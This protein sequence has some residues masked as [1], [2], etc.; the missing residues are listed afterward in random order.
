M[1]G[2]IVS[3]ANRIIAIQRCDA[4][5]RENVPDLRRSMWDAAVQMAVTVALTPSDAEVGSAQLIMS[6]DNSDRQ[7]LVGTTHYI[8]KYTGWL[9]GL[10]AKVGWVIPSAPNF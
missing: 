6:A 3:V 9:G 5:F 1:G 7:Y 4:W 2:P 8:P 10:L